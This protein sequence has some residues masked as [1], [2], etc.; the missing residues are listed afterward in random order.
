MNGILKA[1]IT[2]FV[3]VVPAI[4]D[5]GS[6][7]GADGSNV[8]TDGKPGCDGGT[9]PS[10]DG[11]FYIPGTSRECNP[12]ADDRKKLSRKSDVTHEPGHAPRPRLKPVGWLETLS[13]A[14]RSSIGMTG[15]GSAAIMRP[16]QTKDREACERRRK[17]RSVGHEPERQCSQAVLFSFRGIAPAPSLRHLVTL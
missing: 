1:L 9:R 10:P 8:P 17:D 2:A 6:Y 3:V 7:N 5:A 15:S 12:G 4:S 16:T 13:Y 11:K 14:S